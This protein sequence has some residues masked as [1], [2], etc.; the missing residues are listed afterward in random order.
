MP[1]TPRN[2]R[3]P[4]KGNPDEQAQQ[5]GQTTFQTARIPWSTLIITT[6]LTTVTGYLFLEGIRA[7]HRWAKARGEV[8]LAAANPEG[9]A[10]TPPGRLPNGNFQLPLPE[11]AEQFQ[12]SGPAHGGF[13]RPQ[14]D[15]STPLGQMQQ[16]MQQQLHHERQATDARLQRLEHMMAPFQQAPANQPAHPPQGQPPPQY[17]RAG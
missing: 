7:V 12:M 4:P 16:Q 15:P 13:A 6:G 11:G 8:D 5:Q 3:V 2:R 10:A 1:S 14:A 17:G 9:L